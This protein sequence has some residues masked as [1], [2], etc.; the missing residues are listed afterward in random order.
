MQRFGLS[1]RRAS[2]LAGLSRTAMRYQPKP[3]DDHA[4]RARLKE[5]A[6][7]Y[8]RYGYLILHGM[9]KSEGLV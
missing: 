4:L 9:L 7:R 2:R 6:E 3:R 8:S 5:L 1:E